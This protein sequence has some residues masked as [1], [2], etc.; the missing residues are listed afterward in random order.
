MI[1]MLECPFLRAHGSIVCIF[2]NEL[3]YNEVDKGAKRMS[4]ISKDVSLRF[5]S[6]CV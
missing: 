3:V 2:F 6:S 4:V 5:A 1:S